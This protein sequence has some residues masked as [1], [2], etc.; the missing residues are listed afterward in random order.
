MTWHAVLSV[1]EDDAAAEEER[2]TLIAI[3]EVRR[4]QMAMMTTRHGSD[5]HASEWC[6]MT[7]TAKQASKEERHGMPVHA[8]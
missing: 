2:A 1:D 5:W 4:S 3:A 6:P 8:D 7:M